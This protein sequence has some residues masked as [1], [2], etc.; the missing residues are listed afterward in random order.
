MVGR[1]VR[2]FLVVLAASLAGPSS[3]G[4]LGTGDAGRKLRVAILE[5]QAVGTREV[6]RPFVEESFRHQLAETHAFD[7]VER[8]E[9][10]RLLREQKFQLSG[11]T[12]PDEATKVGNLLSADKVVLGNID[13]V[14]EGIHHTAHIT[15]RL[16]DVGTGSVDVVTRAKTAFAEHVELVSKILARQVAGQDVANLK[17]ELAGREARMRKDA[18]STRRTEQGNPVYRSMSMDS[19]L[20]QEFYYRNWA[21]RGAIVGGLSGIVGVGLIAAAPSGGL[22]SDYQA[23][24]AIFLGLGVIAG[25]VAVATASTASDIREELRQRQASRRIGISLAIATETESS[26]VTGA[27]SAHF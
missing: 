3:A 5:F 18:E 23:G 12:S 15:V 17:D 24:G 9:I 26:I 11:V 6:T 1:A 16:V 10:E 25:I 13:V 2:S 14:A 27:I 4:G 21:A 8:T 22:K 7:L 20:Q 19:L